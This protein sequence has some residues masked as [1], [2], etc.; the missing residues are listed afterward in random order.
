[1]LSFCACSVS[2]ARFAHV[3]AWCVGPVHV[4]V[5]G[6]FKHHINQ[7]LC[8]CVRPSYLLSHSNRLETQYQQPVPTC[9]NVPS[10]RALS[11]IEQNAQTILHYWDEFVCSCWPLVVRSDSPKQNTRKYVWRRARVSKIHGQSLWKPRDAHSRCDV[12]NIASSA[13]YSRPNA[14]HQVP[15]GFTLIT[16]VHEP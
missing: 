3:C 15:H 4:R 14:K 6:M 11:A 9:T 16:I 2:R 10:N 12:A 13:I 5:R 8:V 7:C 1:M